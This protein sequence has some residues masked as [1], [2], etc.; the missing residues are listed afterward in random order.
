MIVFVMIILKEVFQFHLTYYGIYPRMLLGAM[1]I[2]T[3]PFIHSG[4]SHF[5]ANILPLMVLTSMLE[6]F[7]T[8]ISK[9][10]LVFITLLT[11][12]LVWMFAKDAYHI[13]AS[14]IIYGLISF[15][16]WTGLFRGGTRSIIL[17]LVILVIYSSYFD[18]LKPREGVSWESHLFGALA[19]IFIAF[20]LKNVKED[21][22][23]EEIITHETRAHFLERDVFEMTKQQRLEKQLEELRQAEIKKLSDNQEKLNI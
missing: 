9:A 23:I 7:Y 4:W 8:K 1:G 2:I 22:E 17:A 5:F 12:I 18:G 14:G 19:G 10:V 20:I 21:D 15:I 13:G 6:I 11:G 16:F 3:S